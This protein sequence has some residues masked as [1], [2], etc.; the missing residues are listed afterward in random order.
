[1]VR[2]VTTREKLQMAWTPPVG[3]A[4][5]PSAFPRM[6]QQ[7]TSANAAY[8][9]HGARGRCVA[10]CKKSVQRWV[11]DLGLFGNWLYDPVCGLER[12]SVLDCENSHQHYCI[13]SWRAW[14]RSNSLGQDAQ[15]PQAR[16]ISSTS[17]SHKLSN[18]LLKLSLQSSHAQFVKL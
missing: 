8:S 15:V 16:I 4:L 9:T 17:S 10:A 6:L 12:P 2:L 5:S 18:T 13:A 14:P 3:T 11:L 1:M 7:T